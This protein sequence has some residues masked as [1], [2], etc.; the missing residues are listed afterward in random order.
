MSGSKFPSESAA[1]MRSSDEQF[2]SLSIK[3]KTY[4]IIKTYLISINKFC[5]LSYSKCRSSVMKGILELSEGQC[6]WITWFLL[7]HGY[8]RRKR[9]LRMA[10]NQQHSFKG[11]DL[12]WG[13]TGRGP[14]PKSWA[15]I[16]HCLAWGPEWM[17]GNHP[18][19]VVTITTVWLACLYTIPCSTQNGWS[20]CLWHWKSLWRSFLERGCPPGKRHPQAPFGC[21]F[22][23]H[24]RENDLFIYIFSSTVQHGDPVT[25]TCIHSFSH[26]IMLHH[27]WLDKSSK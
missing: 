10:A 11:D 26:I 27:K 18:F 24:K 25:H 6:L 2:V 22:S 7:F 13:E 19:P 16:Y 14:A 21:T 23:Y 3:A 8:E 1:V 15:A 4:Q 12:L 5:F 20:S 9:Q 17:P